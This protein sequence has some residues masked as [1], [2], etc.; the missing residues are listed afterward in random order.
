[1]RN[2]YFSSFWPIFVAMF[3][4]ETGY[5]TTTPMAK[6][7]HILQEGVVWNMNRRLS[8]SFVCTFHRTLNRKDG[9]R[10]TAE[11]STCMTLE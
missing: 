1:M 6:T 7:G 10:E 9:H 2:V 8:R 3:V 4:H 11:V 5:T